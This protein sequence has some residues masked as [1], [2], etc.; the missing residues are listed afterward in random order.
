MSVDEPVAGIT[1]TMPLHVA[2]GGGRGDEQ[3]DLLLTLADGSEIKQTAQASL[4]Y[5]VTSIVGNDVAGPAELQIVRT[6][7]T[8]AEKRQLTIVPPDATQTVKVAWLAA[9][10]EDILLEDRSIPA[11][12][13]IATSALNELLWGPTNFSAYA[14]S[15]PS[16]AEIMT[17]SGRNE[18]WGAR[19]RLLKLV[20][21]DGIATANFSPELQAYGGGSARA[22]MIRQ[23]I[24]AT[25]RQFSSVQQVVI[26]V[27]GQTENVL[28]P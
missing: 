9:G 4:G 14:T 22:I 12:P 24:E 6:N 27:D 20:I 19:V 8:I 11:T 10:T 23:Q 28:Q 25:L 18:T 3:F 21:T 13:Q 1:T 26:A 16:T 15:L 7:G 5:V 2:F 17:Y